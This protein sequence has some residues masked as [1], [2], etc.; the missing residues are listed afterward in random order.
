VPGSRADLTSRQGQSSESHLPIGDRGFRVESQANF[1][2]AGAERSGDLTA[3]VIGGAGV[4]DQWGNHRSACPTQLAIT[5]I[6][7]S[8]QHRS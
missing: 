5:A 1:I 2:R 7:H 6:V 4:V 3:A 8:L